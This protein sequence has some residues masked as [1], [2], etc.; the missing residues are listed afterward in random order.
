MRRT[1]S[2]AAAAT[3]ALVA[4][5][6]VAT[7]GLSSSHREAPLSSLD[8][9]GD[10]TDGWRAG[11]PGIQTIRLVFDQPQDVHRIYLSFVETTAARTQEFVLRW[12]PGEKGLREIVRQQWNFSPDGAT[13]ETEDYEVDL[14]G[15]RVLELTIAPNIS[16]GGDYASLQRLRLA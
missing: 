15:A 4:G 16:S 10:D 12:S 5:A 8:P 14:S 2:L 7:L 13:R 3:G 6:I 11:E 1:R 9:T